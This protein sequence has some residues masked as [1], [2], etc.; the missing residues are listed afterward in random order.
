MNFGT[1][2]SFPFQNPDW[3]KK[4]MIVAVISLVPIIGQIFLLGW[5][6]DITRRV[7]HNETDLVPGLDFGAQLMDGFRVL[8]ASMVYAFPVIVVAI[9]LTILSVFVGHSPYQQATLQTVTGVAG[10]CFGLIATLYSILLAFLLPAAFGNIAAKG[11]LRAGLRFQ[12]VFALVRAAPGAYLTSLLG[13][14]VAGLIATL[15]VILCVVG[16]FL[17]ATYCS[18]VAAYFYGQ[19]YNEATRNRS[20][21]S[22]QVFPS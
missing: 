19:A 3:L 9:P 20:M 15:G 8:G 16:V 1:A 4:I 13:A 14:M 17:T 2:F 6:L 18:M 5:V 11:E 7:I 10:A 21:T 22:L 12:E